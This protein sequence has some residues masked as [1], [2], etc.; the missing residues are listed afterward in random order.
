MCYIRQEDGTRYMVY[1]LE[2]VIALAFRLHSKECMAFRMFIMKRL[3]AS[4]RE[5][6]IH[7]FFSLSEANPRYKC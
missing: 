4:N 5:K 2:M 7:L 3:Y 6:P 1:S